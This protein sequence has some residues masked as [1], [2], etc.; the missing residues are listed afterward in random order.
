MDNMLKRH[1]P[2]CAHQIS[3]EYLKRY[4]KAYHDYKKFAFLQLGRLSHRD[5]NLLAGATDDDIIAFY[6]FLNLSGYFENT[7]VFMLGDHGI[8]SGWFRTTLH[9]KLEERLPFMAITL[10]PSFNAYRTYMKNI[11]DN[12]KLLTSPFDIY[13]TL[14]HILSWP[15]YHRS[16]ERKFGRS[17]FSDM[18]ELNRS[19]DDAGINKHWCACLDFEEV[20]MSDDGTILI[21]INGVLSYINSLNEKYAKGNCSILTLRK[22]RRAGRQI[23]KFYKNSN[24]KRFTYKINFSVSPSGVEYEVSR[25]CT[26]INDGSVDI[27]PST[28]ISRTNVYGNKLNCIANRHPHLTK[29][30]YCKNLENP[31]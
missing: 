31:S 9:G 16:L 1:S 12:T 13:A 4:F 19:C 26:L 5:M 3:F 21:I 28:V 7:V 23:R 14:Q 8:R 2:I 30:C 20:V 6:N 27:V 11:K 25:D 15:H 29:Y 10:P 17:L 22:V 18:K 24:I